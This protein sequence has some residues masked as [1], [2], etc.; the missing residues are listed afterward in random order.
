M[1]KFIDFAPW[2]VVI[3]V[4]LWQNKVFV[5]PEQM[6]KR[7]MEQEQHLETKFVLKET[8]NVAIHEMKQDVTEIKEKIDRMY[9]K[10]MTV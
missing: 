8:Y 2:I 5:T 4:F 1:D 6:E 7:F 9:D 10:L 3:L